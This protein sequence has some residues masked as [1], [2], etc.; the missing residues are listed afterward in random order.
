MELASCKGKMSGVYGKARLEL[1][2]ILTE[3]LKVSKHEYHSGG[4]VG[5]HVD[6]IVDNYELFAPLLDSMPERKKLFLE[7]GACYKPLHFFM[8]RN[9]FLTDLEVE[10]VERC[11]TELGR[12]IPALY[13]GTIPPKFDDLIFAVP[14]LARRFKNLGIFREEKLKSKHNTINV[15]CRV[16][17]CVRRGEERMR[18]VR[19]GWLGKT[20]LRS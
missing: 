17:A 4:Y 3:V 19:K 12:I 11:C 15:L 14:V 20:R 7:Q 13:G 5:K 1:E 9:G 18:Q 6:K 16:L 2:R 8:K 10:E